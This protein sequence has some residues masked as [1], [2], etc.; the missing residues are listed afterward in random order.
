MINNMKKLVTLLLVLVL[1]FGIVLPGQAIEKSKNPL[2]DPQPVPHVD[3]ADEFHNILMAGIDLGNYSGDWASGGKKV[4]DDCHTDMV[5]VVSINKTKGTVSLVSLPR[6]TF[7]YVPGV[8]G[9]YKLNAALNCAETA[10]EGIA[11]TRDAATW[12]LGGVDI[13][14]YFAVDMSAL[15]MLIDAIGGVDFEMDMNYTG[16]SGIA[17]KKGM[18][19]LDGVGVMDY[20]RA[21]KNATVEHNDMGRTRRSRDMVKVIFETLKEKIKN[22]GITVIIDLIS[23]LGSDEFNV[24]TDLSMPELLSLADTALSLGD[25]SEIGSYVLGGEYHLALKDWNF[26]FTDQQ[27]RL[28]VLKEVYGIEAEELPYVSLKYSE[29]LLEHGMP[30]SRQIN[31]A[32]EIINYANQ[33]TDLT[34]EQKTMLAELE[35]LYDAAVIAFDKAADQQTEAANAEMAAARYKL[36]MQGEA[37][38]FSLKYMQDVKWNTSLLWYRD[39]LI[40]EY[41]KIDWR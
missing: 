12:L 7:T 19:H 8:H 38:S 26:T 30:S 21:R 17:Y 24:L 29:W 3:T 41:N 13:H 4:L 23:L 2:I 27:N 15:I 32:K 40:N 31:I 22:D 28:A 1:A 14:N 10:E 33:K 20:V 34:E 35:T 11:R 6:D 39:P 25:L 5:M 36:R 37:L 18:Q 9:V 16:H